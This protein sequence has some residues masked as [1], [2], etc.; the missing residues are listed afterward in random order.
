MVLTQ[1]F[2]AYGPKCDRTTVPLKSATFD[3]SCVERKKITAFQ[4][5]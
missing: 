1:T 4:E 2:S 3:V 5:P